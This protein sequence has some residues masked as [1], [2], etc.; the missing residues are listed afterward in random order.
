L[1]TRVIGV[2]AI[3]AA[4]G[5]SAVVACGGSSPS[6]STG[7]EPG[8]KESCTGPNLCSG[9]QVCKNDR[10]FD[11]CVCNAVPEAGPFDSSVPEP[12]AGIDAAIIEAGPDAKPFDPKPLA[13]TNNVNVQYVSSLSVDGNHD[14]LVAGSGGLGYITKLDAKGALVWEKY[15]GNISSSPASVIAA[16]SDAAGN[17]YA[18]LESPPNIDYGGGNI[19]QAGRVLLKLDVNGKYVWHYGPFPSVATNITQLRTRS[20]GN[21]VLAGELRGPVDFGSGNVSPSIGYID[22]LIVELTPAK[23]LVKVKHFGSD[24]YAALGGIA[25]DASG[26]AVIDGVF[27]G[28]MDFGKGV[29]AGPPANYSYSSPH[30]VFVAKLDSSLNGV[31]Q[32]DGH[33]TAGDYLGYVTVDGFGNVGVGGTVQSSIKLGANPVLAFSGGD[34]YF[35]YLDPSLN[36]IWSGGYG[37]YAG[38]GVTGMAPRPGGGFVASG[39]TGGTLQFGL[40]GLPL[41]TS[42]FFAVQFDTAGNPISNYGATVAGGGVTTN[43]IAYLGGTDFVMV[44]TCQGGSLPMPSGPYACTTAGYA[45]RFAP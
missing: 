44:G 27:N 28:T 13:W 45:A 5:V 35:A 12:E 7:C 42:G 23:T 4:T 26:N 24:G 43:A 32:K 6:A 41:G 21:I 8:T 16:T 37:G 3:V 30:S 11:V 18:F 36:E 40:G 2:I 19:V 20:N 9:K 25:L 31:A 1:R 17:V 22:I 38:Q 14:I 29:M 39:F 34:V 10:T 15:Y 33:A